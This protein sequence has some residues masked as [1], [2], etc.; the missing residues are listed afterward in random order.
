MSY[1]KVGRGLPSLFAAGPVIRLGEEVARDVQDHM[2][3]VVIENTP[4]G[5]RDGGQGRGGNLRTSWRGKPIVKFYAGGNP[6]YLG[7]VETDVEYAPDVE[8]GTGLFGPEGRKYLIEAKPGKWLSWITSKPL[9]FKD[10]TVVPAG[11]RVFF[12][13]VL[14]P[15]SPGHHMVAI[16]AAV[17]EG[18]L[19]RT[20][21]H[22]LRAFKARIERGR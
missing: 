7:G 5:G 17:A 12:K 8:Y 14:H 4:I 13:R 6:A 22:A 15:G 3:D 10:G 16:A 11:E 2:L 9:T 21:Q 20:T 1:T 19:E 18:E